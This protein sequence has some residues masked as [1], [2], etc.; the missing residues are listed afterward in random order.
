MTV[1]NAR[2][3]AVVVGAALISALL[4]TIGGQGNDTATLAAEQAEQAGPWTFTDDRGV[5]VTLESRPQRIVA[6]ETAASALWHVG[7]T[8]VGIFGGSTA[9]RQPQPHRGGP[10]R[11]RI[12]G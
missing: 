2:W 10:E 9:G 3:W 4:V 6:Y 5:E 7:I 12:G 11:H 1:Q 8:P